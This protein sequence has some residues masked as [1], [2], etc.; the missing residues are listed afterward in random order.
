M[1]QLKLQKK[2]Q[3]FESLKPNYLRP[4]RKTT[5]N[6]NYL[7]YYNE[8][9]TKI[10]RLIKKHRVKPEQHMY[11]KEIRTHLACQMHN[12]NCPKYLSNKFGS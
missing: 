8:V 11:F 12:M 6:T 3:M 7:F 2:Q 1:M 5:D 4:G 9:M 10:L